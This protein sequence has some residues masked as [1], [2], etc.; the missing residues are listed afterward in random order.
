MVKQKCSW[1]DNYFQSGRIL[2]NAHKNNDEKT[3]K[4]N[5]SVLHS[6]HKFYQRKNM[7]TLVISLYN[8]KSTQ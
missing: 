8:F 4:V 3:G 5:E 1:N 7:Q 2:F 6:W